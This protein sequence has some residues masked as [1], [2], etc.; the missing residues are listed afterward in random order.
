MTDHGE[1]P[2]LHDDV[3]L[4]GVLDEVF[5]FVCVLS[6]D[7]IVVEVN[8]A[9]L[10]AAGLKREDVVGV[11]FAD[12]FWFS[13]SREARAQVVETLERV[14]TRGETVRADFHVRFGPD[15]FVVNDATFAPLRGPSGEVV[16]IVGSAVEVTER[17]QT[18]LALRESEQRFRHLT[19]AI[20]EV[21]FLVDLATG[22]AL[23]ISPAYEQVWGRSCQSAYD[24]PANWEDA[25]H[26]DDRQRVQQCLVE[27]PLRGTFDLE[28][29][30][31]RP[32]GTVRWIRARGSPV[33][34]ASGRPIRIAGVA[35]DITEKRELEAQ[36]RQ[37]QKMDGLGRLAGGVAHDFN[38][39]LMVIAGNADVLLTSP[40]SSDETIE[41]VD[42][43]RIASE[44]AKSLTRQLLLFSRREIFDLKV[45]E[46]DQ[47]VGDGEKMLRRLLGEDV[48]VR[49]SLRA[50]DARVKIDPGY[51]VQIL[52]NLGVNARDAMP[53]GGKLTI[54]TGVTFLDETY[55]VTHGAVR[56]GRYVVIE[57]ADTGSGMSPDVRSR[58]F[59]PFFT[60]KAAGKGTG[61]GL[62]V[63]HGIVESS[64]GHIDV[65]SEAGRGSK[66]RIYLP[67]VDEVATS[68]EEGAPAP[69]GGAES[70][71]LVEDDD[72]LRKLAARS[73]R[74]H[75][76][77][78][79]AAA[80]GV[81]ALE[82]F[83]HHRGDIALLITDVVMPR[84]SGRQLAEALRERAPRMKV[85][86]MSGYTDDAIVRHGVSQAEVAFIEKP[87]MPDALLSKVRELLD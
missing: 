65:Q 45:I 19:G 12:T 59:D 16:G 78:V 6:A 61:L 87:H 13:H 27:H 77:Q 71:L 70:V 47:A 8:R 85:L 1:R 58:A 9:P 31:V 25:I 72:Q 37:A 56:P 69:A 35:E 80:D 29:R 79:I 36:L 32:D 38:N 42:D 81:E 82:A 41:L 43:I 14:S 60:T 62:S 44:R 84:M 63:V 2:F 51:L 86:Y 17:R 33:R 26:P 46:L 7:G 48:L 10:D 73:L 55:A 28:Y 11:P 57:V 50:G 39:L 5:A 24:H 83:E 68:P 3:L 20:R 4:R 49:S 30:I 21:F 76:Y 18:E 66:F 52:V 74:G 67:A 15:R 34:D 54:E 40:S 53:T 64:G 75:G 23:Y 22:R